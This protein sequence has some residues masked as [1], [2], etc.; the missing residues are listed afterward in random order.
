MRT[1]LFVKPDLRKA[2][3]EISENIFRDPKELAALK[4]TMKPEVYLAAVY[5]KIGE[6]ETAL[7]ESKAQSD[8]NNAE[9]MEQFLKDKSQK[10]KDID[11]LENVLLAKRQEREYLEKPLIEKERIL[12]ER[13]AAL[14]IKDRDIE[15]KEQH[16]F[17]REVAC[18]RKLESIQDLADML[19]EEKGKVMIREQKVGK[20]EEVLK[21]REDMHLIKSEALNESSQAAHAILA[22]REDRVLL[23]ELNISSKDENLTNREKELERERE[24]IQSKRRALLAAQRQLSG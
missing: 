16:V 22:V 13:S 1:R 11:V 3:I 9:L 10:L 5:A 19:S 18:E 7:L 2:K 24:L 21:E 20:R 12:N 17:E 4:E 8:K 23:R 14:D 15:S 6:V